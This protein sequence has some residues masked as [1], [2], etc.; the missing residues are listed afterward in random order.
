MIIEA[1]S[2]VL[3]YL[4]STQ[5]TSTVMVGGVPVQESWV[6]SKFDILFGSSDA[7]NIGFGRNTHVFGPDLK[8]IADWSYLESKLIGLLPLKNPMGSGLLFGSGGAT[9]FIMGDKGLLNYW[10]MNFT[11]ERKAEANFES[12]FPAQGKFKTT[13]P[14]ALWA[15]VILGF[16]ALLGSIIAARVIYMTS[17]DP[18]NLATKIIKSAVPAIESRWVG[19]IKG[20]EKLALL[21]KQ[22][23]EKAKRDAAQD[24]LKA[25]KIAA[26]GS[27]TAAFGLIVLTHAGIGQR[28]IQVQ[29]DKISNGVVQTAE[30]LNNTLVFL[31]DCASLAGSIL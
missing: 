27:A 3:N 21:A 30:D 31:G 29:T 4:P 8:V 2:N 14:L 17:G 23:E 11:V 19:I 9:D 1:L 24:V 10:G 16:T 25:K 13:M 20:Y 15:G 26:I 12:K 5:W 28:L 18:K 22:A 6:N 7:W